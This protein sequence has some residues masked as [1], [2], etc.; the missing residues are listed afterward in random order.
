MYIC[1]I[2]SIFKCDPYQYGTRK[3]AAWAFCPSLCWSID[4]LCVNNFSLIALPGNITRMNSIIAGWKL[5][6]WPELETYLFKY[7]FYLFKLFSYAWYSE[8]LF[9]FTEIQFKARP[10]LGLAS[11]GIWNIAIILGLVWL[12]CAGPYIVDVGTS[13]MG[14]FDGLSSQ[15]GYLLV[16]TIAPQTY[17]L[18]MLQVAKGNKT[19]TLK[20]LSPKWK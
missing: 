18:Y 9:F 11:S 17:I 10:H 20:A 16:V 3:M 4:K 8:Y 1:T 13:A 7:F 19:F 5:L 2:D 14:P 15:G 6:W 12:N